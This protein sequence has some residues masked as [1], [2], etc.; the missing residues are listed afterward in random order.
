[1]RIVFDPGASDDLDHIFA[2]IAQENIVAARQ[3]VERIEARIG[4]LARPELA[5]LGRVGLVEGTRELVESPYIIVY[6]V[7]IRAAE[8]IVL[9]IAHAAQDRNLH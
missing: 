9:A 4:R 3:M 5:H 1:M 7:D 8:V 6:E 2:W